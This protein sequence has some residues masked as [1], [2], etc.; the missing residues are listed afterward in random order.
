MLTFLG[1]A[2]S[3]ANPNDAQA[4]ELRQTPVVRAVQSATPAVVNIRGEKTVSENT[5]YG[6][7]EPARRVNGMGTGVVIDERGYIVTNHHVVRG[8]R[9]IQVTA[10]GGERYV[11]RLIAHDPRTDLAIIKIEP[12]TPM[13]VIC[14][15]Q[16]LNSCFLKN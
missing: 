16:S 7:S 3:T 14:I 11:A 10:A 1:I 6:Q 12:T 5:A 8:V 2:V 13:S 4:S 15:G 9:E